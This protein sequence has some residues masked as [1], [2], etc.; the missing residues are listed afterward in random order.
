MVIYLKIHT[1]SGQTNKKVVYCK[2]LSVGR[3][4]VDFHRSH[5][6]ARFTQYLDIVLVYKN[7][8]N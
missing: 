3:R 5:H 6:Q 4:C 8:D 7:E 2:W 1:P